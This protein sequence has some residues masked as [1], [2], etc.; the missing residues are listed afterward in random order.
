MNCKFFSGVTDVMDGRKVARPPGNYTIRVGSTYFN[1]GGRIYYVSKVYPNPK[2]TT[3]AAY[4]DAGILKLTEKIEY[5][6]DT[7]DSQRTVNKIT[8]A[9]R[10]DKIEDGAAAISEGN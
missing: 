8:L 5:D 9:R 10:S 6:Y 4:Y 3:A 1:K 2:Y 7:A